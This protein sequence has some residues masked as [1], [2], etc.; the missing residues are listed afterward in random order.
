MEH[1]ED[2]VLIEQIKNPRT[3]EQ[4]FRSLITTYKERL[5]WHIRKLVY[6]H[7]DADDL[8][9]ETFIKVY[10]NINRFKGESSLFS[11]MYR[12]AT[13]TAL[14]FLKTE[15]RMKKQEYQEYMHDRAEALQTDTHYS[16]DHIELMLQS[17]VAQLPEKQ[18]LVFTMKYMEDLTYKQISEILETSEGAL[19]A[20][21]FHAVSK[22]KLFIKNEDWISSLETEKFRTEL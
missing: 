11:W 10:K 17:A 16:G 7:E 2:I 9:Q 6:S 1:T 4:G 12:I 21:Y 13:N 22:I 18:Q 5:Y 20:S 19:K 8:L 3:S 14:S 15:A